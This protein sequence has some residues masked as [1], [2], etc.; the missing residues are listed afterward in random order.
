MRYFLFWGEKEGGG[1]LK[2]FQNGV[3]HDLILH[4]WGVFKC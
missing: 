4:T 3:P 2:I 1:V